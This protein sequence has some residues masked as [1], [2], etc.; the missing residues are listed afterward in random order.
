MSQF[1][2][3][4]AIRLTSGLNEL[5]LP[6]NTWII[7]LPAES[8]HRHRDAILRQTLRTFFYAISEPI[9][10][11]LLLRTTFSPPV[12]VLGTSSFHMSMAAVFTRALSTVV[13]KPKPTAESS[14]HAPDV[15]KPLATSH[16]S[17]ETPSPESFDE[18]RMEYE[19][20]CMIFE[21]IFT[22]TAAA[23]NASLLLLAQYL[24]VANEDTSSTPVWLTTFS[25]IL[26]LCSR[27]AD[28][29]VS[30][31]TQRPLFI[32]QRGFTTDTL[33]QFQSLIV[34]LV[35]KSVVR[36]YL[37]MAILGMFEQATELEKAFPPGRDA[38]WQNFVLKLPAWTSF[39]L[40]AVSVVIQYFVERRQRRARETSEGE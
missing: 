26:F 6:F 20:T 11:S 13:A 34:Y 2:L 15:E 33:R 38:W 25:F 7:S 22:Q 5:I 21:Y 23:S 10:T 29:S 14:M 9:Y 36:F 28:Y 1:I 18:S 35:W 31:L 4:Q 17:E 27:M 40:T 39:A 19:R 8:E 30:S 16:S 32:G 12:L 37:D 24:M 3:T